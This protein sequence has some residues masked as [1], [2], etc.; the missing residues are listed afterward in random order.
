[1]LSQFRFLY[2]FFVFLEC[3]ELHVRKILLLF[4]D[5]LFISDLL[6]FWKTSTVQLTE[7]EPVEILTQNQ[8]SIILPL[9]PVMTAT[10]R[11]RLLTSKII[12]L[13]TQGTRKWVPSPET[14]GITPRNLSKIT[15]LCPPSTKNKNSSLILP[16]N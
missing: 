10:F 1:M 8:E 13:W 14:S 4:W 3:K 15:A 5:I 6:L 11:G 7:K 2:F 12:G 16:L 9:L